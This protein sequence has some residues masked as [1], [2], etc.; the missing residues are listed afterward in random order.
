MAAADR[1]L[2]EGRFGDGCRQLDRDGAE[3]EADC[4]VGLLDVVDGESGDR[5]GPLGIEEQQQADEAVFGLERV[6][7]QQTAAGGPARLV[8]HRLRWA[9]RAVPSDGRAAESACD[10]LGESQRTKCPASLR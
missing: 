3:A 2:L 8:V 7:V 10:L 5:R 1:D 6:I 4:S 9:V